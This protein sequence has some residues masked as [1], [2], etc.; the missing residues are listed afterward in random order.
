MNKS[1]LREQAIFHRDRLPRRE[2]DFESVSALFFKHIPLQAGQVLAGY[3]PWGSEFDVRYILDDALK[4]GITCALP[5]TEK[6]SRHM[7]FRVWDGKTPLV[8]GGFGLMEPG[9]G[10]A[11]LPDIV[12]VPLLAFDRRGHRLG[13]GKGYYDTALADLRAQK[14][15]RAI[16]VGYGEQAVLFNLPSEPHDQ[17]LD[18]M[19]T[20]H[21]ITD[22]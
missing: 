19:I 4:A 2:A 10:A 20:P 9:E 5:V 13:Y 11:I 1:S 17:K 21:G 3:W 7:I 6:G 15:I 8:S 22:F 18:M 12:L 14:N 16:G